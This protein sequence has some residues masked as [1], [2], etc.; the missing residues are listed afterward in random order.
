MKLSRK[1]LSDYVEIDENITVHE[2]AEEMTH[3]GNEYDSAEK[4]IPST[5]LII[6]KV[7]ECEN[8]PDSPGGDG[9]G[10]WRC[11]WSRLLPGGIPAQWR[12]LRP[13]A[14]GGCACL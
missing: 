12:D 9:G 14:V 1:F 4:L 5:K 13:P 8:H 6:G 3:I 7:L 2:L 10:L 11:L